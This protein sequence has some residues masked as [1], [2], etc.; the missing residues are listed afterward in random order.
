LIDDLDAK[1]AGLN[2]IIEATPDSD[3]LSSFS[4]IYG[5]YIYTRPGKPSADVELSQIRI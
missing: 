5:R 2:S 1:L 4:N 3:A